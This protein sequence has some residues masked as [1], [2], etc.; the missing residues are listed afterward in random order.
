ME[1]L[2]FLKKL[3][4]LNLKGNDVEKNEKFFRIFIAGLLP[5]LTYYE[6]KYISREE[7]DEGKDR[8]RFKLREIMDNEKAEVQDRE[9]FALD[10]EKT[11]HLRKCFVEDLDKDQLFNSLFVFDNEEQGECLLKIGGEEKN[12]I[13][14]FHDQSS[15]ITQKIY[16]IGLEQFEKRSI[17]QKIF[18]NCVTV[19]KKKIQIQGQK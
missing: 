3:R 9:H 1:R 12:L 4:S 6:N 18:M 8:F 7:R 15:T 11:I 13:S 14:E 17:E 19:G 16:K 2:R 5:Q 10:K